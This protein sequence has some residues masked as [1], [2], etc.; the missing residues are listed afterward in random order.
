MSSLEM[1]IV[2]QK[3]SLHAGIPSDTVGCISGVSFVCRVLFQ[4]L[5]RKKITP[6]H[7]HT[8]QCQAWETNHL[9]LP[10]PANFAKNFISKEKSPH[11]NWWCYTDALTLCQFASHVCFPDRRIQGHQHWLV[12]GMWRKH[13]LLLSILSCTVI[14][15]CFSS[16]WSIERWKIYF[17]SYRQTTPRN[18]G[19]TQV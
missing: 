7:T 6:P 3:P 8:H 15:L 11:L 16:P 9:R 4:C 5:M 17:S 14:Y 1:Q 18:I 13:F 12:C 2:M 10:W 19:L